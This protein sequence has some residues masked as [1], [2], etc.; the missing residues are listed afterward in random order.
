VESNNVP[1]EKAW[2][3]AMSTLEDQIG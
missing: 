1:P 3:T 2:E